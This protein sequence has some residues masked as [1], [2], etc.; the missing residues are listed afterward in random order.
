MITDKGV[1]H[2]WSVAKYAAFGGTHIVLSEYDL[3]DQ[4]HAINADGARLARETADLYITPDKPRFVAGS[5]GPQTKT[6]S[7]TGGI[8]FDE[9][10]DAFY[11]QTLGLLEGDVDLFIIETTQDTLNLKATM[12]GIERACKTAGMTV[13]VMISVT[14]EAMGTMLGGQNI[15]SLYTSIVHFQPLSI[16][17]N[18]ATGPEFMTDHLRTLAAMATVPVSCHPNAGLPDEE[19]NYHETPVSLTAQLEHFVERGW[20][21]ILGGCCGTT[22]A[23]IRALVNMVQ[24]KPP[25]VPVTTYTSA[26]SGTE[27]RFINF[28]RW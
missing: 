11:A 28:T 12:L 3:Q 23:H 9:V 17:L 27:K 20:L 24:G 25:R 6:I 18:C 19:G 26:V 15:E 4:V 14:I 5:L 16:G 1:L 7:V 10:A 22:P 8:T 13:P 21:N 2:T